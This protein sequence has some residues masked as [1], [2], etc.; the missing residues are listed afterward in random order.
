MNA[1]S[2][3]YLRKFVLVFFDVILVYSR[4]LQEYVKH[5]GMVFATMEE[6]LSFAKISKCCFGGAHIQYL[7]RII[8]VQGVL[9]ESSKI[10]TIKNQLTPTSV[11][12]LRGF[13]GL[14]G[15]YRKFV[16]NY[17]SISKPIT[18][19]LNKDSF[20]WSVEIEY[21]FG[22]L[23][24]AMVSTLILALPN[25]SD[26][27]VVETA[28][29]YGVGAVLMHNGHLIAYISKVLTPKQQVFTKRIF[30]RYC[31]L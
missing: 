29:R 1:T 31:W 5:L 8:S 19:I 12:P 3:P 4:N 13:F 28:F 14:T 6:N 16:K 10:G 24:E 9:T 20:V 21:S 23:K 17:G 7:D 18:V 30:W 26:T 25:M 11:K 22:T 15:Y 27:F 2:K